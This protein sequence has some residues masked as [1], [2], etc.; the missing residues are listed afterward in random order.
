MSG[1]CQSKRPRAGGSTLATVA[2]STTAESLGIVEQYYLENETEVECDGDD[3]VA[4]VADCVCGI[5]SYDDILSSP[6][7]QN[8]DFYLK[9][10]G[11]CLPIAYHSLGMRQSP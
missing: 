11:M 9:L 3:C 4:Q 6:K 5:E 8:F 1:P 10:R 7:S 2:S